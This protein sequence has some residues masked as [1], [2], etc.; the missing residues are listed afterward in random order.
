M[1]TAFLTVDGFQVYLDCE[2][3]PM[4]QVLQIALGVFLGATASHLVFDA[5]HSYQETIAR[6]AEE[7]IRLEREKI[8]QETND[9]IRNLILQGR[10][11]QQ[12]PQNPLPDNHRPP[13]GFI[14]DDAQPLPGNPPNP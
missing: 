2:Y 13:D 3:Q 12:N 4:K 6:Q 7:K 5:W 9:R 8:R 11:N 1:S 10:Q 14:P